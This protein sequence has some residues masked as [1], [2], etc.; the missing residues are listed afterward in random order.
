MTPEETKLQETRDLALAKQIA[1]K[2][3]EL[4][5]LSHFEHTKLSFDTMEIKAKDINN[6]TV[7]AETF[8]LVSR[9]TLT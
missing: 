5:L 1:Q 2:M 7:T 4:D 3:Q 6:K 8:H 9:P